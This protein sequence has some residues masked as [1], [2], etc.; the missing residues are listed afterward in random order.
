MIIVQTLIHF[1]NDLSNVM[2]KRRFQSSSWSMTYERNR[3]DN[4]SKSKQMSSLAKDPNR[5]RCFTLVLDYMNNN[6]Y[7]YAIGTPPFRFVFLL[8]G[9][10]TKMFCSELSVRFQQAIRSGWMQEN[11]SSFCFEYSCILV[12]GIQGRVIYLQKRR[13]S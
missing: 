1:F 11:D 2:S 13:G 6:D 8:V 9:F 4:S 7:T 3:Y 10:E 12:L 5:Q